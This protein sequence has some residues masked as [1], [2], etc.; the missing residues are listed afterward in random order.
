MDGRIAL[1]RHLTCQECCRPWLDSHERW[2]AYVT[3]DE[4]VEPVF[5]CPACAVREFDPD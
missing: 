1:V 3:A 5:Y 4:P 2:R